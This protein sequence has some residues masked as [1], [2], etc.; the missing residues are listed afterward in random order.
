MTPPRAHMPPQNVAALAELARQAP[1]GCF[2]EVGVYRGGTAWHLAQIARERRVSLHLFDTFTGMPFA[3]P[4]DQDDAGSFGET[5]LAEVRA[6]IPDAMFHVGV[7]PST[8]PVALTGIAFLHCDC[9]QYRSVSAVIRELWPRMVPGGIA[10]F[11][12]VD[13]PGGRRA[14]REAGLLVREW[15]GRAYAIAER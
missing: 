11:D 7:F 2:V 14:I 9:D 8:L 1:A 12:D 15:K 6:A 5:S 3:D 4:E 13:T 10:A